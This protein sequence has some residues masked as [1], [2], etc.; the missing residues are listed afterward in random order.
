MTIIMNL[1]LKN[2]IYKWCKRIEIYIIYAHITEITIA[3]NRL[4]I[5]IFFS[6]IRL[7][8]TQNINIEPTIERLSNANGVIT[9]SIKLEKVLYFLGK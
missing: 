9:G 4:A 2:C 5:L 1:Q 6:Q 3:G 8:P 7:I